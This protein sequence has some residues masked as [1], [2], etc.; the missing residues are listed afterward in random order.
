MKEAIEILRRFLNSGTIE[1]FAKCECLE[2]E[3]GVER[4]I[5]LLSDCLMADNLPMQWEPSPD[6]DYKI[7][8]TKWIEAKQ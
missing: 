5:Q 3:K 1:S 2:F 6:T 7:E 8:L 4:C